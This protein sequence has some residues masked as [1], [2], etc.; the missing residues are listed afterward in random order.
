MMSPKNFCSSILAAGLLTL[1]AAVA[2]AAPVV[3]CDPDWTGQG[4]VDAQLGSGVATFGVD[5]FSGLAAAF[6]ATDAGGTLNLGAGIHAL[7][8]TLAI[9]KAITI[10]GPQANVDPRTLPNAG[11]RTAGSAAEA[12]INAPAAAVSHFSIQSSNVTI[13]G[14]EFFDSNTATVNQYIVNVGTTT[15]LNISYNILV[16]PGA[17]NTGAILLSNAGNSQ[18]RYNRIFNFDGEGGSAGL[19]LRDSANLQVV[20]N[21]LANIFG[22]GSPGQ[23]MQLW[24]CENFAINY[25]YVH[26]NAT[27][28]N[29][30]KG[31][32]YVLDT[33]GVVTQGDISYNYV[34]GFGQSGIRLE[35][36]GTVGTPIT[37]KGNEIT[38]ANNFTG[39]RAGIYIT[40]DSG[41]F[42]FTSH[43]RVIGNRVHSNVFNDTVKG[44]IRYLA[45]T[46]NGVR[47]AVNKVARYNEIF[48]N[49]SAT[50]SNGM[51]ND[52]SIVTPVAGS[53]VDAQFNWWGNGAAPATWKQGAAPAVTPPAER[54]RLAAANTSGNL[55]DV[56]NHLT[57]RIAVATVDQGANPDILLHD[58]GFVTPGT[59]EDET[60]TIRNS[61][62]DRPLVINNPGFSFTGDAVFSVVHPTNGVA[63]FPMVIPPGETRDLTIRFSPAAAVPYSGAASTLG[64]D[65]GTEVYGFLLTGS[66]GAPPPVITVDLAPA[67]QNVATGGTINVTA[68]V[69]DDTSAPISGATVNFVVTAGPNLGTTDSDTTDGSG[70]ATFSYGA[71]AVFGTDSITATATWMLG[72]DDDTA[73]AAIHDIEFTMTTDAAFAAAGTSV[74]HTGTLLVN[75]V[76]A[77]GETVN[78]NVTAGP[79]A[80]A[81]GSDTTDGTGEAIISL[82]NNGT[83]GTDTI[84][85]SGT[86]LGI[87][88][89][90]TVDTT[91]LENEITFTPDN[92]AG[93]SGDMANLQVLLESNGV[94]VSGETVTF[95]VTAGPNT[96]ATDTDTSDGSGFADFSY[97]SNGTDGVDTITVTGTVNGV[98]F[99]D[100]TTFT[101]TTFMSVDDWTVIE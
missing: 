98:P 1:A 78:F 48:N 77:T 90:D 69:L 51:S 81:N 47:D 8:G 22:V 40:R 33:T 66:G 52:G 31:A 65:G 30:G 60:F 72:T 28:G 86:Y 57:S 37:I 83:G 17:L 7:T 5:A 96:G 39:S 6:A 82:L 21:E 35:A 55:L 14:V 101:W 92:G 2:H 4:D 94:P 54:A 42:N 29:I 89:S 13:N 95:E 15:N 58:F 23:A 11:F 91:F 50:L 75:G 18:F 45:G 9:N 20:G 84:E 16:G 24:N 93:T 76:A 79:D 100:T 63:L 43:N 71:G 3:Y 12:R 88:F 64:A 49:S 44:G 26:D 34:D 56:S 46:G 62:T 61:S 36:A 70:E 85:G 25:N 38:R 74:D 41:G 99:S 32:I 10:L 19:D 27:A 68:T 67:T 80:G 97:M 87:P 59:T 53:V 73:T